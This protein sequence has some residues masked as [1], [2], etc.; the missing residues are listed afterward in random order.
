[1]DDIRAA[2]YAVLNSYHPMTVRQ[3]FYQLVSRRIIAKTEKEYTNIVCLLMD[4]P[5]ADP[6]GRTLAIFMIR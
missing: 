4:L 2:I 6:D 3:C 5:E 1:M